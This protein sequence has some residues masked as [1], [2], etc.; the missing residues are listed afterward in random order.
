MI[1][2]LYRW[3]IRPGFE[4]QFAEN[5]AIVTT[6]I[7][8]QCGSFG[9]RLHLASNGDHVG[10]AQWPDLTT[11]ASCK[12]DTAAVEARARMREAIEISFKE[13]QLKV[14]TDLLVME[15]V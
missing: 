10:Y 7:R 3:K 13:E 2:F 8:D 6:A 9:S 12:L 1:V 14:L 4:T 11:K 15:K 5:W